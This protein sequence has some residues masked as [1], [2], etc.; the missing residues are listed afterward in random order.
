[1]GGSAYQS[2]EAAGL[3]CAVLSGDSCDADRERC[4]GVPAEPRGHPSGDWHTWVWT[5]PLTTAG[6]PSLSPEA[7]WEPGMSRTPV[8]PPQPF[9]GQLP[10]SPPTPLKVKYL[11]AVGW[12]PCRPS[13]SHT[14]THTHM[15]KVQMDCLICTTEWLVSVG[16]I[17]CQHM[18]THPSFGKPHGSWYQWLEFPSWYPYSSLH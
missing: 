9:V 14:F 1:M 4:A 17:P 8:L 16:T 18:Q 13:L 3:A 5:V 7:P 10:Q 11:P 12:V 6:A 15:Y 2:G